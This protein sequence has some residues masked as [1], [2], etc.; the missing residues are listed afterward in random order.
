MSY[1]VLCQKCFKLH[2]TF[3][4]CSR[5]PK[6][7]KIIPNLEVEFKVGHDSVQNFK[8]KPEMVKISGKDS[9]LKTIDSVS[10]VFKNFT[11]VSDTLSGEIQLKTDDFKSVNFF[12]TE[13]EY[14]LNVDRFTEG[15]VKVPIKVVNLPP[16]A[17]V[18]TFPKTVEIIFKTSLSN[19]EKIDKNDFTV[20]CR[21]DENLDFM[22][23]KVVKHPK[24]LKHLNLNI[25][26]VDYLI[27]R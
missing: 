15:K 12:R 20:E 22:I 14:L 8:F 11:N 16:N 21:Y 6:E 13:V 23:P 5:Q 3:T 26:K 7:I 2:K 27:K 1:L 24:L 18:T 4:G 9:I 17:E 10:T 19:F 25:N